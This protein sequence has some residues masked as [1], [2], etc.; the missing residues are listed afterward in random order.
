MVKDLQY[1]LTPHIMQSCILNHHYKY[2]MRMLPMVVLDS[3]WGVIYS[4]HLVRDVTV[5]L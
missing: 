5:L 3:L 2:V 1:F 4:P